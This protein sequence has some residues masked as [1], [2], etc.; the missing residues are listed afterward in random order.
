MIGNEIDTSR[1]ELNKIQSRNRDLKTYS[2][3]EESLQR[4]EAI[5]KNK[6]V[7][8]YPEKIEYIIVDSKPLEK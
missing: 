5:A 7:M 6:L 8:T 2:A 4:I 3:K 1:R